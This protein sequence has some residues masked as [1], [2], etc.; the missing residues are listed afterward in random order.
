VNRPRRWC[1]TKCRNR[2]LYLKRGKE[3]I[4]DKV[5]LFCSLD[6]SPKRKNQKYCSKECRK[7]K[8]SNDNAMIRDFVKNNKVS[9]I[10]CRKC[11]YC[12]LVANT[13]D[14][15]IPLSFFG[16]RKSY[17]GNRPS[18]LLPC[19]GECNSI[20]GNKVFSLL[21]EKRAYVQHRL[22]TKYKYALKM[23]SW[24]DKEIEQMGR[25]MR[26]IIRHGLFLR[27]VTRCR[28][29][30]PYRKMNNISMADINSLL[31]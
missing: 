14:H 3:E 10:T 6:F 29:R 18:N 28:V 4:I 17:D 16:S 31:L 23:P 15:F 22:R 25:N 27:D 24:S 30:Y 11:I 21:S 13:T 26:I 19:C 7:A 12:G 9:D 1:S 20:A 5:C 2:I 8:A